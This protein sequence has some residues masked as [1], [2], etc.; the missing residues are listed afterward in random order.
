MTA[1]ELKAIQAAL[2]M[3][4][5]V[6]AAAL[7]VTERQLRRYLI[8]AATV[9]SGRAVAARKILEAKRQEEPWKRC[10]YCG[11]I[12]Q[13]KRARCG[14]GYRVVH[15]CPGGA[16]GIRISSAQGG[17]EEIKKALQRRAGL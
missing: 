16:V 15:R 2:G 4:Q 17:V 3:T 5:P 11:G 13:I 10:P 14:K 9:D 6:F 1:Q 12:M 7:G 8:G